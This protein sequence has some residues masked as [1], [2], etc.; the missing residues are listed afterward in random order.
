MDLG[1]SSQDI[2]VMHRHSCA[3]CAAAATHIREIFLKARSARDSPNA[4]PTSHSVHT[5]CG[6]SWRRL[7]VVHEDRELDA[8]GRLRGEKSISGAARAAGNKVPA[9]SLDT[10]KHSQRKGHLTRLQFLGRPLSAAKGG[11][12]WLPCRGL[13]ASSVAH[14]LDTAV[15]MSIAAKKFRAVCA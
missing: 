3:S 15:C 12:C 4:P 11:S 9:F 1:A 13:H 2:D 14:Y 6:E 5:L 8:A 10:A 7:H